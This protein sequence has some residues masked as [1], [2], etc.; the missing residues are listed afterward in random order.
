LLRVS[1]D[2]SFLDNVVTST[3]VF[4]GNR[5]IEEYGGGYQD[6][7]RQRKSPPDFDNKAGA[8][9]PPTTTAG[10]EA[11]TVTKRK[12]SYKETQELETLPVK[13]EQLE[14]EQQQ[15]EA[16]IAQSEFYQQ[17][18]QAITT[19]MSR[20]EV[21]HQELLQAYARWEKLDALC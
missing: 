12:L 9:N 15:I 16:Q 4:E 3:I 17:D 8:A 19:I 13:I 11:S 1:P 14:T 20:L 6:Y 10:A 18:P 7:L 21:I 2:R 5:N